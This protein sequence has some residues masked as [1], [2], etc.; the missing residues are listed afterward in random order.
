MKNGIG[1]KN[2][3][4]YYHLLYWVL[5]I[6]Y[7][8]SFLIFFNKTPTPLANYFLYYL[9]NILLFY[10]HF[11]ILNRCL[12]DKK[13]RY[14]LLILLITVEIIAIFLLKSLIDY[15]TIIRTE[16]LNKRWE[17]F[18]TYALLNVYR[19]IYYLFVSTVLWSAINFGKFRRNTAE[20][21]LK[22]TLAEKA[23]SDLKYQFAQAQNAF[24]KQQINPH[25]LFNV[26]NT[27]YSTVYINSPDDSKA[28]L[29]LSEI[30]R[31]SFEETDYLG[32]APL[33]NE[34]QQLKNL[35]SLN[36]F[37]FKNTIELDLKII[38]DPAEYLVIPLILITLTENMFKHGDLRS[39]PRTLEINI[40]PNGYISYISKN[41][42]RAQSSNESHTNVG[43]HNTRLRLDY[44]YQDNYQLNIVETEELFTLELH[45]N[46]AYERSNY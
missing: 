16:P 37:R 24:L 12:N 45:I 13:N 30:M 3:Y 44:A 18:Q 14:G 38:G 29:L 11:Y 25:L 22:S 35:V 26:L 23:N 36:S 8:L 39:N 20:A 32:R 1:Q 15:F 7:E 43:L 6:L 4:I 41:V 5:Y 42:P 2:L 10:A 46:L 17:A 19:D 21:L 33:K 9:S 40:R 31:Y 28:V 27:I 34:I